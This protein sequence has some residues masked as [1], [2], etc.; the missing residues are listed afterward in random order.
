MSRE[1]VL[2]SID[3]RDESACKLRQW[4]L[5]HDDEERHAMAYHCCQFI[6]LVPNS[7]VVRQR[8]PSA[9]P[10]IC[11]PLLV[12]PVGQENLSVTSN[13]QTR[14]RENLGK[15]LPEIT[16]GEENTTQAARS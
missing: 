6:G 16:I 8:N 15:G 7:G 2:D 13:A 5:P 1:E 3:R 11:K 14:G 4:S 12:A 9:F 10:N